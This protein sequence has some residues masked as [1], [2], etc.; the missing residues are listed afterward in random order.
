MSSRRQFLKTLSAVALSQAIM[1]PLFGKT[2]KSRIPIAFS[3][4]GC[5]AWDWPRILEFAHQH[6]FSAI[7]LRGLQGNLDLPSH[8]VFAADRIEQTK[9]EIRDHKLRIACVSSSANL[10]MEDADKRAKELADARRFIDLASTLGAPY[11]RVF[12]GKAQSDNAPVP[13]DP[14]KAR[15]AAGLRELG[16]YAGPKAVTVIIESHDHFTSSATLKDVLKA[17]DSEHVG[18]LW[19]AHH[20]FAASN[21]DPEFTVKQLGPWIRHTHLKDSVGKGEDRK[22][23]LTGTGN[24]PIERQIKALQSIGYKDFYC[25][26]WEK[27]WHPELADPEIA[28]ADFAHV[29]GQCLGNTHACKG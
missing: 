12:G 15:V 26:E 19:D 28:I 4:L 22:Y 21:E 29:V 18:L 17:A 24:V 7:E 23:V 5:P 9:K 14:T 16:Q 3:T 25:F 8:A 13:D 20:T 6:G 10:Y 11:V 27:V 1:S 2:E